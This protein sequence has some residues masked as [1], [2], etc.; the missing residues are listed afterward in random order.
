MLKSVHEVHKKGIIHYDIKPE[1]FVFK[2][3]MEE[4]VH[5]HIDFGA[6]CPMSSDIK[7]Y[8]TSKGYSSPE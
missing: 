3:V 8:V 5:K 7:R 6:A 1:N 2:T 4:L